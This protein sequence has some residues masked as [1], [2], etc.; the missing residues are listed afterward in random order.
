MPQ[1]FLD[2]D[3]VL[4]DFESYAKDYF[5]MP[6]RAYEA[7]V[8]SKTFW[9]ELEAKGNFYRDLPVLPDAREL[10]EGVAHLRPI[11]LTG[12][13]R[14][15]WARQQK[16]DWAK[17]HFPELDIIVCR[18]A[19]KWKYGERGDV[20]IDDWNEYR[21]RWIEMGGVWIT[22]TCAKTSLNTLWAHYP[23]TRP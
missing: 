11:I 1:I 10:V 13:P 20:I 9:A 23:E 7:Q 6:P 16:I 2:C 14:G 12:Q 17:E 18:S 22:H 4:A 21:H 15:D 19:D 5:G 8:G 3:G